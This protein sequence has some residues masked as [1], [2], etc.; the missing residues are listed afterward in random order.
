MTESL[1]I[2]LIAAAATIIAAIITGIF[3]YRQARLTKRIE[4]DAEETKEKEDQ[5]KKESLLAMEL[6]NANAKLTVGVAMALKRGHANGEIEEGLKAV[7]MAM[8]AYEAYL[9]EVANAALH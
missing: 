3:A 5:R 6:S 4:A 9:R 7:Q 8:D 2:A 1:I